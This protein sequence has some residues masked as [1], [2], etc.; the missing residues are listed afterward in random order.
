MY[1]N[2]RTSPFYERVMLLRFFHQ[3]Q[4]ENGIINDIFGA[5]IFSALIQMSTICKS[6]ESSFL[7]MKQKQS[8]RKSI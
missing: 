1:H 6:E 3:C 5:L 8:N 4:Q 7:T 2:C